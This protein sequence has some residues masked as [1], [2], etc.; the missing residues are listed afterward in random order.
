MFKIKYEKDIQNNINIKSKTNLDLAINKNNVKN[1]VALKNRTNSDSCISY[2]IYDNSEEVIGSGGLVNNDGTLNMEIILKT[3]QAIT[4]KENSINICEVTTNIL[5]MLLKIGV[6]VDKENE[7]NLQSIH[8]YSVIQKELEPLLVKK[9]KKDAEAFG[10]AIN[11]I[12]R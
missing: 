9:E 2:K 5:E 8:G 4:S 11:I 12:L 6:I 1:N 3:V 10:L 7:I